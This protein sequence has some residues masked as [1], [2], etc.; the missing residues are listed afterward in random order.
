MSERLHGV[1]RTA[2]WVASL[3]AAAAFVSAA[4]LPDIGSG[5]AGSHEF[6][7]IRTRFYDDQV[8][9]AVRRVCGR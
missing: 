1:G 4:G 8:R 6:L 3:R 2:V 5:P 7:A 9:A